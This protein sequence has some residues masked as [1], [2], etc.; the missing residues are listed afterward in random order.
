VLFALIG[1]VQGVSHDF[2]KSLPQQQQ[3]E[4][5]QLR[6]CRTYVESRDPAILH[7]APDRLDIPYPDA[8]KLGRYLDDPQLQSILLFVPGQEGKAGWPTQIAN[9]LLKGSRVIFALG[10]LGL[11]ATFLPR[12]DR[13]AGL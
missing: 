9:G 12:P 5:E 1:L 3:H 2:R 11:F 8:D 7:H 13:K 4:A 10:I 6:R